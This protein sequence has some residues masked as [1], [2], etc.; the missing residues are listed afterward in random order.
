M[1][2]KKS[3]RKAM[4]HVITLGMMTMDIVRDYE[5]DGGLTRDQV[6]KI[7]ECVSKLYTMIGNQLGLT[8]EVATLFSEVKEEIKSF[9][10]LPIDIKKYLMDHGEG[11]ANA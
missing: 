2:K 1:S 10:D 4:K 3:K 5:E 9:N 11:I 6:D 7:L 8:D